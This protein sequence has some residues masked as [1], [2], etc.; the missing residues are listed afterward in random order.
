MYLV[1]VAAFAMV[2]GRDASLVGGLLTDSPTWAYAMAGAT[3]LLPLLIGAGG[4]RWV[5]SSLERYPGRPERAQRRYVR[6]GLVIRGVLVAAL[7]AAIWG[8][9]W[10][11]IVRDEWGLGH[12]WGVEDVIILAPFFAGAILGWAALYPADRAIRQI[13]IDT[14]LWA[15][16]PPRPVWSFS[17]YLTFNVRHHLLLIAVPMFAILVADDLARQYARPLAQWSR[18]PWAGPALFA[19]LAGAVFL[20]APACLRYVWL[21]RP[22]PPGALRSRLDAI[23]RGA[24]MHYRD[25]LLWETDEMVV[26]A[27]V[28]GLLAPLRY[29]LLSDGLVGWMEEKRI[30]AVFGHEVGHIKHHHI[31][32][33]L[34]VAVLCMQIAGGALVLA[35]DWLDLSSRDRLTQMAAQAAGLGVVAVA[36]LLGFGWISRRFERQADVYGVQAIT[37]T[38]S[39][40]R[41]DCLVHRSDGR[42]APP[43]ALCVTAAE[44]FADALAEVALLNGIPIEARSWRHSSIASRIGFVRRLAIDPEAG[45]RFARLILFVKTALVVLVA[46]GSGMAAPSLRGSLA[47]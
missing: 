44:I 39:T 14:A 5:L 29:V 16:K 38:I 23:A 18:I 30:E 45:R 20:F 22:L 24:G 17:R 1:V 34:L 19:I 8:T 27:A 28:M 21:T 3:A 11:N 25:I 42:A 41:P 7:A 10:P 31:A 9:C 33:Y 40:C 6:V 46:I 4:C 47:P 13:G 37:P 15:G 2:L 43:H 32:F 36:F 35:D 26:N 12:I